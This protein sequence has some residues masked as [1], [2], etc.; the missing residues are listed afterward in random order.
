MREL[1]NIPELFIKIRSLHGRLTFRL[2]YHTGNILTNT[3]TFSA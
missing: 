1:W 3:G 2:T